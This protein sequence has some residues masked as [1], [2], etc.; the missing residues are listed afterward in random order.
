MI[1]LWISCCMF[2]GSSDGSTLS[3]KQWFRSNGSTQNTVPSLFKVHSQED[4][5]VI[6]K[7]QYGAQYLN[8]LQGEKH[9]PRG[10]NIPF[11]GTSSYGAPHVTPELLTS[12]CIL[13]TRSLILSHSATQPAFED[14]SP[15]TYSA[16]PV[17]REFSSSHTL[18]SACGGWEHW[19]RMTGTWYTS[20]SHSLGSIEKGG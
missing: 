5:K 8:R 15:T 6:Q 7:R 18:A 12:T 9:V 1:F 19:T 11:S 3:S 20:H 16:F 10:L 13:P 14:T 4:L 17:L 2:L